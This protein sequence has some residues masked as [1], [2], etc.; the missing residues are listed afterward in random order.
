M[1]ADGNFTIDSDTP[2]CSLQNS[3]DSQKKIL[4]TE[5][6]QFK[7]KKS[8]VLHLSLRIFFSLQIFIIK[9]NPKGTSRTNNRSTFTV[10]LVCEINKVLLVLPMTFAPDCQQR[11]SHVFSC[12]QHFLFLFFKARKMDHLCTFMSRFLYLWM[13][14]GKC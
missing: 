1:S 13:E 10:Q 14:N 7:K 9:Y 3:C 8:S 2:L 11:P 5:C 6:S 4:Y 12:L